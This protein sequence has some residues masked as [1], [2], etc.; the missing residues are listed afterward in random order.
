MLTQKYEENIKNL[1]AE[2][3]AYINCLKNIRDSIIKIA[4]NYKQ[5]FVFSMILYNYTR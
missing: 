4:E 1:Q 5:N 2:I 3:S